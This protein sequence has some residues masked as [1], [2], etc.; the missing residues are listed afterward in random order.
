VKTFIGIIVAAVLLAGG[1]YATRWY[2]LRSSK[3]SD[4]TEV[5]I[6]RVA[7]GDLTEIVSAPGQIQPKDRVQISARV[8]ARIKALPCEEGATVHGPK[9]NS[10]GSALVELDAKEFEAQLRSAE[11]RQK[12]EAA[13]IKVAEARTAAQR[14]QIRALEVELLDAQ[15]DL[16]R[17]KTLFEK[18]DVSRAILDTADT[19][20]LRFQADIAAAKDTLRADE[21]NLL[22]LTHNMEAAEAE[23]ARARDAL[24]YTIITSPIDGV[25][26]RLNAKVG[27]LVMTGTMNNA[28]TVIMEVGDLSKMLAVAK[29]DETTIANVAKG[30]KAIVHIQAY[31][32]ETFDGVVDTIALANSEERDGTKYYKTEV[33]LNTRG[34]RIPC[35]LSCDVDIE[36]KRHSSIVKVPSQAVLGRPVDELPKEVRDLPQ[37]DKTKTT[38][39]VVY[40]CLNGKA[41][42]TPVKIGPSDVT[43]TI[44]QS[45]LSN[46]DQVIVGPYKVLE[47]LKNDQKVKEIESATTRPAP[48]S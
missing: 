40:R 27:E 33:L 24:S 25:V 30:Q 28:G 46:D 31:P 19:K 38:T 34:K 41:V 3:G 15:R 8:A 20:V 5:R 18:G 47:M 17:Q 16:H 7:C 32:D 6:V 48:K 1:G 36:V 35:G 10:P 14:S 21:A 13:Q 44:I 42:V 39:T 45:G 43:H 4:A 23:I 26:T 29:L 37:V 11:A 2:M 12:A 22:V 9:D